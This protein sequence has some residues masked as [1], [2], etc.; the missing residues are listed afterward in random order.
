MKTHVTGISW[1]GKE[2][3]GGVSS[4]RGFNFN[5]LK[6]LHTHLQDA[7]VLSSAIKNYGRLDSA[8]KMACCTIA[9][10]IYDAGLTY[11]DGNL[12]R[13][14]VVAASPEG[15]LDANLAY[16]EDYINH[17][18]SIARG[19]LF[20]YTLPSSPLADAAIHFGCQG[21]LL[22][23]YEPSAP[24]T[25]IMARVEN[26]L[27]DG[28]ATRMAIYMNDAHSALCLVISALTTDK[29]LV[30]SDVSAIVTTL[31]KRISNAGVDALIDTFTIPTKR[32][33]IEA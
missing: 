6:G 27:A 5:S 12:H 14:G 22:Y 17:G 18:R 25:S 32:K 16:F 15:C 3:C 13:M 20:V 21:P 19:S 30:D 29:Y 2:S 31:Q 8:S 26:F 23:Q 10:G 7:S 11:S 4:D 1:M 9:M 28:E 24:L 33:T